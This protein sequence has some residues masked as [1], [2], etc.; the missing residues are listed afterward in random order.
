MIINSFLVKEGQL[1]NDFQNWFKLAGIT[2]TS[3]PIETADRWICLRPSEANL[4]PDISRTIV[5]VHDC[6]DHD[7]EFCS[8][9]KCVIFTHPI[10][11]YLWQKKGLMGIIE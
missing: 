11:Y 10:Q 1:F 8:N 9:A 6:Y 7:V 5:Q 3:S 4:S 2:V